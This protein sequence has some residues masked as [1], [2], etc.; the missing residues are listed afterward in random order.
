MNYRSLARNV[1]MS[2]ASLAAMVMGSSLRAHAAGTTINTPVASVSVTTAQSFDYVLIDTTTVSGNVT[3]S[4][5][6]G[7][8]SIDEQGLAI[9]DSTIGG[10]IIN[11]SGAEIAASEIGIHVGRT[12]VTGGIVNHG[13]ITVNAPSLLTS[14]DLIVGIAVSGTAVATGIVNDGDI[15]VTANGT[16]FQGN[17]PDTYLPVA[18]IGI[19][20][21]SAVAANIDNSGRISVTAS[22]T[23][24][25]SAAASAA[26]IYVFN[27]DPS[28]VEWGGVS[29][30]NSGELS[31]TASADAPDAD[32]R[33]TGIMVN[34]SAFGDALELDL[35]NN[36]DG[37]VS[38]L[39]MATGAGKADAIVRGDRPTG[40]RCS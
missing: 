40:I 21:H 23:G 25:T 33:A 24:S 13:G 15:S 1:L 8:P 32:A 14:Q 12:P 39:A 6:I 3:N 35:A 34:A 28:S 27:V 10:A 5:T 7:L 31:I 38:V 17:I 16:G 9:L 22:R 2:G 18:G 36:Y 20:G 30:T 29:I 26:G 4:G 11:S 37:V 19:V